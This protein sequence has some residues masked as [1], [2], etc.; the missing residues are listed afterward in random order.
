V[1]GPHG[2]PILGRVSSPCDLDGLLNGVGHR[3]SS[4][5]CARHRVS[6]LPP[7][8]GPCQSGD[9]IAQLNSIRGVPMHLLGG[10]RRNDTDWMQLKNSRVNY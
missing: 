2:V 6:N 1:P 3:N 4:T 7:A 8:A 5:R 9:E 10:I